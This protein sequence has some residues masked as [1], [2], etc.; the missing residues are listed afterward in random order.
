MVN[1]KVWFNTTRCHQ[2]FLFKF[3]IALQQMLWTKRHNNSKKI[4]TNSKKTEGTTFLNQWVHIPN[5]LCL[6]CS[7]ITMINL[8]TM[9]PQSEADL[10]A[11]FFILLVILHFWVCWDHFRIKVYVTYVTCWFKVF[12]LVRHSFD[13]LRQFNNFVCKIGVSLFYLYI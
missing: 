1:H 10:R 9:V 13:N 12:R 3:L 5:Y 6:D 8:F 4:V 11:I 7:V 2:S